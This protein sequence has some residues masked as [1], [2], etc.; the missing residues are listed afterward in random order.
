MKC[1]LG[2]PGVGMGLIR[3]LLGAGCA[4]WS[5][6]SRKGGLS[7]CS[8]GVSGKEVSL[9][10]GHKIIFRAGC[11]TSTGN[12]QSL[13]LGGSAPPD[14]VLLHFHARFCPLA[15]PGNQSHQCCPRPNPCTDPR[16]LLLGLVRWGVYLQEEM[17]VLTF[18]TVHGA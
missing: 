11:C 12:G 6:P 17:G 5:C 13:G 16:P 18:I 9:C 3:P 1:V 7:S 4:W 8:L 14:S 15:W 2:L 10:V